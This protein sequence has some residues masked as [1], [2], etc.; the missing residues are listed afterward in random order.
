MCTLTAG[1]AILGFWAITI[2]T[3]GPISVAVGRPM[4]SLYKGG[5]GSCLLE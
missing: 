4:R 2:S 5:F 3:G 1:V